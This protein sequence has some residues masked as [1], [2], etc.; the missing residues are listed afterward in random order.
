MYK[1]NIYFLPI[2]QGDLLH[3]ATKWGNID[4][5]RHLIDK[6]TDINI[7]DDNWVSIRKVSA[8][9]IA[10]TAGFD[11]GALRSDSGNA[12]ELILFLQNDI[13]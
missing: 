10:I 4:C 13:I 1:G 6:G 2:Y 12:T 5:V 7:K 11:S 3:I 8:V 9:W